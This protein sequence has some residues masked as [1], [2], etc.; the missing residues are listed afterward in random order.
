VALTNGNELYEKK[1]GYIFIVCA[2][3]KTAKEMLTIL[4]SRINN[5]PQQELKIAMDEQNKIT[6]I[7]LEKLLS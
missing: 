6:K 1:F 4:N 3:G 5:N 2:T 7:R